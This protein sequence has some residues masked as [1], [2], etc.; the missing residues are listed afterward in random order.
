MKCPV[1][2]AVSGAQHRRA[3]W[4]IWKSDAWTS[5]LAPP[6]TTLWPWI[7]PNLSRAHFPHLHS[8]SIPQLYVTTF[9]WVITHKGLKWCL[10]HFTSPLILAVV[11]SENMSHDYFLPLSA[12]PPTYSLCHSFPKDFLRVI[13]V[14]HVILDPG[15]QTK[16]TKSCL[17][18]GTSFSGKTDIKTNEYV[19]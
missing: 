19:T 17:I 4:Y 5:V 18:W 10:A 1:W 8:N 7:M 11:N 12:P 15:V 14:P 13:H 2:P 6:L 3:V 16:K 9:A